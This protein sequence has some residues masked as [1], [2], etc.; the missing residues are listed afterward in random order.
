MLAVLLL[1]FLIAADHFEQLYGITG[2]A[3]YLDEALTAVVFL[4]IL[5]HVVH[6]RQAEAEQQQ[7]AIL[8]MNHHVR[9]ALQAILYAEHLGESERQKKQIAESVGRIER[10]VREISEE[11]GM[12]MVAG[13]MEVL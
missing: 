3:A 2:P 6:R 7:A 5:V 9:N 11:N 10:A 8:S 4:G 12:E 13:E 1:A